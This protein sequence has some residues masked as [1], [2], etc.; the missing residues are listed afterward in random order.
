M[1]ENGRKINLF[2][3]EPRIPVFTR[4]NAL[5]VN[6]LRNVT[7]LAK[8]AGFKYSVAVTKAVWEAARAQGA[9]LRNGES[10]HRRMWDVLWMLRVAIAKHPLAG[11]DHVRFD[12]LLTDSHGRKQR[13]FMWSGCHP[14][15]GGEPL[16]TIMMQG[17]DWAVNS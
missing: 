10:I 11:D 2:G 1:T 16:I 4:P 6:D 5:A 17:E 7:E 8:E 13:R 9:A 15:D 12:V 14:G 3:E